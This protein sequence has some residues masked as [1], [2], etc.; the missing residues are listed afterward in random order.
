MF[1]NFGYILL[2]YFDIHVYLHKL[3][4]MQKCIS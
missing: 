1:L 4:P 3:E 2:S